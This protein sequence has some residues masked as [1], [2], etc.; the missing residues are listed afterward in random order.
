MARDY[1]FDKDFL[2]SRIAELGFRSIDDFARAS[3]LHRNTLSAYLNGEKSILSDAAS[4]ISQALGIDAFTHS[5]SRDMFSCVESM[6]RE[7]EKVCEAVCREDKLLVCVLF[8]SRA[9]GRQH[10]YSDYDIGLSHGSA[11]LCTEDY[12]SLRIR[13]EDA[14]DNFPAGVDFVNLD[15]AELWFL[16]E[17][18]CIPKFISGNHESYI[19]LKGKL[20]GIR[21]AKEAA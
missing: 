19:Y 17:I 6:D 10:R 13:L 8:G 21:R 16:Q 20:D 4:R 14:C 11:G 7:I 5:I 15:T 3:G 12:L 9:S 18:D 1:F 2:R